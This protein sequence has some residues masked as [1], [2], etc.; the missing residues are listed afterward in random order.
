MFKQ[1]AVLSLESKRVLLNVQMCI[2]G[3]DGEF[4]LKTSR[5]KMADK[6]AFALIFVRVLEGSVLCQK[7]FLQCFEIGFLLDCRHSFLDFLVA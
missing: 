6:L 3:F 7:G 4:H 5:E 1:L 2:D